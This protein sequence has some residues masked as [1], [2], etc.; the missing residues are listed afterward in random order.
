[1][2]KR[3]STLVLVLFNVY[4]Q[5]REHQIAFMALQIKM[6]YRRLDTERII[7]SVDERRELI[8]LGA[9]FDHEV[10]GVLEV[11]TP[12]TY[13]RWLGLKAKDNEPAQVGRKPSEGEL[14]EMVLRMHT[15]NPGWGFVRIKGELKKLG[16]A[17]SD[18]VRNFAQI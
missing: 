15:E 2:F 11:V 1:M 3:L 10:D 5:R 16:I 12:A 7:P 17:V 4:H 13:R 18:N 6:L 9:K 8:A 14:V